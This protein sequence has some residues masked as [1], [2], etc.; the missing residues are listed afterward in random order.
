LPVNSLYFIVAILR[1]QAHNGGMQNDLD[2]LCLLVINFNERSHSIH[3]SKML[4]AYNFGQE[5]IKSNTCESNYFSFY[6]NLL[7]FTAKHTY[8]SRMICL[9]ISTFSYV[10]LHCATDPVVSKA[11]LG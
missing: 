5:N 1:S 2:K 4:S 9:H 8:V 6:T 7:V 3:N 10:T 11:G